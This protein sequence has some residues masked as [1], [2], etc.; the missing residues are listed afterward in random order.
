MEETVAPLVEDR[1]PVR[2]LR[3]R[4]R[5][6][7]GRFLVFFPLSW[8]R[9]VVLA[10][11]GSIVTVSTAASPRRPPAKLFPRAPHATYLKPFW[12]AAAGRPHLAPSSR[13]E[14]AHRTQCLDKPIVT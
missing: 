2:V 12:A 6:R 11:A 8:R 4:G 3:V 10:A 14:V 9:W 13:L 1:G 5:R 7:R